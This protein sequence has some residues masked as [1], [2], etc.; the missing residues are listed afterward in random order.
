MVL[1]EKWTAL[2]P[3]NITGKADPGELERFLQ[4][5]LSHTSGGQL[6]ED[7]M[8]FRDKLFYSVKIYSA[9]TS[10]RNNALVSQAGASGVA[11]CM[12]K[13][14]KGSWQGGFRIWADHLQ[15]GTAVSAGAAGTAEA[16]LHPLC[17]CSALGSPGILQH[18]E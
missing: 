3:D 15:A 14:P 4:T 16:A 2:V 9:R 7:R 5:N 6:Q 12:V 10:R 8:F 18:C 11:S 13:V 1:A 17:Y